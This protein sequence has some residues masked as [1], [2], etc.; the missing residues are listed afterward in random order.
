MLY[1]IFSLCAYVFPL[2]GLL[3]VVGYASGS[4]AKLGPHMC[5]FAPVASRCRSL[6]FLFFL[7]RKLNFKMSQFASDASWPA[8][9]PEI[10]LHPTDLSRDEL[11]EEAKGW[12]LFVKVGKSKRTPL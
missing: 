11:P 1:S 10:H 7:S 4:Q 2:I 8:G 5:R 6:T 12:L 3:Q 9:I